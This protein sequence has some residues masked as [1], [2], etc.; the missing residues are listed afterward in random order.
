MLACNA[1]FSPF[2]AGTPLLSGHLVFCVD[3]HAKSYRYVMAGVAQRDIQPITFTFIGKAAGVA[4][5]AF[6]RGEIRT[7]STVRRRR[8]H[9]AL[10]GTCLTALTCNNPDQLKALPPRQNEPT[11]H[12]RRCVCSWIPHLQWILFP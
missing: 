10:G 7:G 2:L 1:R 6:D 5:A 8:E 12:D 4:A 9:V 3:G 11:W